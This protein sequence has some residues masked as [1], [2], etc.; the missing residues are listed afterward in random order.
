ML[1]FVLLVAV[2]MG[3]AQYTLNGRASQNDCH[4]YTLTPDDFSQTGSIWNNNKINLN[5][6][7][8]FK[9]DVFL[10]CADPLGADGIAFVL[11]PI[12]TSVGTVGSGL[13]YEGVRPS[14]G[15]TIDTWQNGSPSMAGPDGDPAFDHIAIQLNGDLNHKDSIAPL[16]INNIAGPVTAISGNDNIEDC[17]WHILRI[18]WDAPAKTLTAYID[19][20]LR[21]SAV[22]DL[23]PDVFSGDPLV[24]W[25]FTGSTGGSKN[26]QQ[27]CT[28][29]KPMFRIQAGQKRCVGELITFFDSTISFAPLQ[30]F[31]W[32]FG[33][34]SPID[35]VNL[36]PTHTFSAAGIYTI[37]QTVLGA[38][39][40][41]EINAQELTIG[42]LPLP[43][44]T[45]LNTCVQDSTLR[46]NNT[47]A[48]AFGTINQWYWDLGDGTFSSEQTP[49]KT[50]TTT[51][52]KNVKLAVR[53]L[54]GCQS[55]TIQQVIQVFEKPQV[56]FTFLDDRCANTQVTFNGASSV[57]DGS[58]TGWRWR[59]D[60]IGTLADSTATAQYTF[61]EVGNYK[62][63]L[64]TSSSNGCMSNPVTREINI[65]PGP[66]AA[67]RQDP[68]CLLQP[69]S[70]YDSSSSATTNPIT[71]WWWNLGNGA[72]STIQNPTTTYQ[73]AGT[74]TI[75]LVV[76]TL[77]GCIS[78]T[79][80]RLIYIESKPVAM[81]VS[82][83]LLCEN[84]P[85]QLLDASMIDTG[86]IQGWY[87]RFDETMEDR[88]SDPTRLL[89]AG[90]HTVKLVVKNGL[91]C[92]SDTLTAYLQVNSKPV[93]DFF[94]AD[95]C[96]NMPVSFKGIDPQGVINKWQWIFDDGIVAH[97]KD[98][99][100]L[101][102]VSGSLPVK[103][104]GIAHTGC[105]SD[106]VL[107]NI[108][109]Y[110][111]NA[112]AGNDTIAAANQPI[113][114]RATGGISYE[115]SPPGG[116]ND[117]RLP[118]PVA[119][120]TFDRRYIVRAFTPVGCA[121]YDTLLIK[122]YDGPEIYV[123]RAFS[124]NNDGKNEILKAIP[125]GISSFNYFTVY[126][127]FG[128]VMFSTTVPNKGWDGYYKGKAQLSGAYTWIA[129]AVGYSGNS[130]F[131]KGTVVLVR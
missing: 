103:L 125:V 10:G 123:P 35:S 128:Q 74:V 122:I 45:F 1:A 19:G 47:S 121:S 109:I 111:T 98:T 12:S 54:E 4:C 42:S 57:N 26:L 62:V 92:E 105:A 69:V 73:N 116:L 106:T 23:V 115:W 5:Q 83:T 86:T 8:D 28:A 53:S 49:L 91:G 81:F 55:D 39:G 34:G 20:D 18:V 67:F 72:T 76:T 46:I 88:V 129:S 52:L 126:N 107:K 113:Q 127:R 70:L 24:F 17:K 118:N 21:V 63:T 58:I 60:P 14:V 87:W 68:P 114:L 16:P 84:V 25:G 99:T 41:T 15:V 71:G 93:V 29:L 77:N 56:S 95:A 22:K 117:T 11:Q 30:K 65:I 66:V 61:S 97:A 80:H 33:D 131:R 110:S 108:N 82:P 89:N 31:Y 102:A 37:V 124:P 3:S 43:A 59:V 64:S 85:V 2:K 100:R 94:P 75:G 101:Y 6:S 44:F 48:T 51:G 112:F 104:F 27:V 79:L 32:D 78:D 90:N 119:V 7:F 120:N 130:L 36:N 50:Y 40:C 13:G 9:F 96:I 38:D